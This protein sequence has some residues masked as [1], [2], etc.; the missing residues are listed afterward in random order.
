LVDCLRRLAALGPGLGLGRLLLLIEACC[1]TL[2][3][4]PL[5]RPP[6]SLLLLRRYL[7]VNIHGV[8]RLLLRAQSC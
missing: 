6:C 5:L 8:C 1:R 3:L 4:P 7:A 2:P